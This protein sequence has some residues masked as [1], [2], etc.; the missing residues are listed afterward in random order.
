LTQSWTPE[1]CRENVCRKQERGEE[2][3]KKG[4]KKGRRSWG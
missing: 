2:E 4:R 3:G 1:K